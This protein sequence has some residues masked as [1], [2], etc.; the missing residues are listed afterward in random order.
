MYGVSQSEIRKKNIYKVLL[1][2]D[3]PE[4]AEIGVKA[5]NEIDLR[6][7][8]AVR[9]WNRSLEILKILGHSWG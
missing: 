2:A 1:R 6:D 3:T 7:Y 4:N 9:S 8:I 5:A